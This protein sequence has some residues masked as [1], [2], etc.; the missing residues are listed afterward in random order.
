MATNYKK[1]ISNGMFT[2]NPVFVTLL[3][4]CPTLGTTTTAKNGLFMG[5]ATMLVLAICNVFIS[6]F[7][8]VI[9]DKVRIP[10][11]I[12]IIAT[13]VTIIEML[14]KAYLVDV[15]AVLG[16]FIPLIVVNCIVLGRAESFANK[17]TVFASLVDG[18]GQGLGF[19]LALTILG[20]I[21]EIIGKGTLFEKAFMPEWFTPAG[22]FSLAPGAFI[23]IGVI[24]AV[25]AI[26]E[27]RKKEAK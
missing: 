25:M 14:M 13:V 1:I 26:M 10:G 17:N 12:M 18:I 16:I 8:K 5:L 21:R 19:T 11:Y 24:K 7:K 6:M 4:L 15:Y 22:V 2:E 9:P 20:V 23:T 27:N 3:G